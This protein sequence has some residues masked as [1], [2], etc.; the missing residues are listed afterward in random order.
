[1]L[2]AHVLCRVRV[3]LWQMVKRGVLGE[4][5]TPAHL[6]KLK[7]VKVGGKMNVE[8]AGADPA[9]AK[10][11]GLC[12]GGTRIWGEFDAAIYRDACV[13]PEAPPACPLLCCVPPVLMN[14]DCCLPLG[15]ATISLSLFAAAAKSRC[16]C[17]CRCS[18]HH[19]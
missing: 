8:A 4:P 15:A 14:A 12:C 11:M 2:L 16:R 9:K 7:P 1:M 13:F 19:Q 18:L 5:K 10:Y 17:R 3:L 6:A